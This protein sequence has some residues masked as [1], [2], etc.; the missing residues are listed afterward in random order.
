MPGKANIIYSIVIILKS[1]I[2]TFRR[3]YGT[4]HTE[5]ILLLLRDMRFIRIIHKHYLDI[6]LDPW[7]LFFCIAIINRFE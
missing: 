7:S 6:V 1:I 4:L 3:I 5:C 2:Q